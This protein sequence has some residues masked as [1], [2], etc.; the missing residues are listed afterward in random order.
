[1][2]AERVGQRVV[3]VKVPHHKGEV[4]GFRKSNQR[5]HCHLRYPFGPKI[6]QIQN[7]KVRERLPKQVDTKNVEGDYIR[8]VEKAG[9]TV[10]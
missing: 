9:K 2:G 5:G 7:T 6:V 10:A 1:M 4:G 8:P 3:D